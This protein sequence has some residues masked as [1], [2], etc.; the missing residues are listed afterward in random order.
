MALHFKDHTRI[1]LG[2]DV[3]LS[4]NVINGKGLFNL[5]KARK[6]VS[7]IHPN[8]TITVPGPYGVCI[9]YGQFIELVDKAPLVIS[10]INSMWKEKSQ[11]AKRKTID[12]SQGNSRKSIVLD[13]P[14]VQRIRRQTSRKMDHHQ[15]PDEC[16][17][18]KNLEPS[19]QTE[20]PDEE[21]VKITTNHNE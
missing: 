16:T 20:L 12:E 4:V 6:I 13:E 10:I 8:R 21:L 14:V 7:P 1:P 11:T 18:K 3:F 9:S 15:I 5:W 2:D 17:I 19:I